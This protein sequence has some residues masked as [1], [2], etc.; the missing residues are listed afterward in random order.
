MFGG[1]R[2]FSTFSQEYKQAPGE[3]TC[4]LVALLGTWWVCTGFEVYSLLTLRHLLEGF[5]LCKRWAAQSAFQA[6][7]GVKWARRKAWSGCWAQSCCSGFGSVPL[8]WDA[9]GTGVS[10][11]TARRQM[12]QAAMPQAQLTA[13]CTPCQDR[14]TSPFFISFF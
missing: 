14:K 4:T 8:V 13:S 12:L 11:W 5:G 9:L 1:Q 10:S 3:V 2:Y 7:A 6:G